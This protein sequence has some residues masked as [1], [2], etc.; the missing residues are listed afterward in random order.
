MLSIH[1]LFVL[2]VIEK[3][4][5]VR[6]KQTF[7][8][9]KRKLLLR[10]GVERNPGPASIGQTLEWYKTTLQ[11]GKVSEAKIKSE[12]LRFFKLSKSNELKDKKLFKRALEAL[13]N[14]HTKT[15]KK[16]LRETMKSRNGKGSHCEIPPDDFATETSC[17]KQRKS[18]F[19]KM[20]REE[21]KRR[22]DKQA[23]RCQTVFS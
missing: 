4:R 16:L 18:L 13:S 8:V 20:C 1:S 19:A 9:V 2:Q 10:E 23:R 12:A 3:L 21:V 6:E 5:D 14:S 17:E 11:N 7:S 15:E 22:E